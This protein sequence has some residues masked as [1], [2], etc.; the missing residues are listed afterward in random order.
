[1]QNN[2]ENGW[3]F[4]FST[5]CTDQKTANVRQSWKMSK[6]FTAAAKWQADVQPTMERHVHRTNCRYSE[7]RTR[8]QFNQI[9]KSE[10]TSA[11]NMKNV[12]AHAGAQSQATARCNWH[13]VV[14]SNRLEVRRTKTMSNDFRTEAI[15]CAQL[16]Y[17]VFAIEWEC[18]RAARPRCVCALLGHEIN[19]V[20]F[21][22]ENSIEQCAMT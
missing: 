18:V 2:V 4:N 16:I 6:Y 22:V 1:M 5:F 3:R 20:F 9:I 21:H 14:R 13:C 8:P 11:E 15:R 19:F 12:V 17:T 10:R 7:H